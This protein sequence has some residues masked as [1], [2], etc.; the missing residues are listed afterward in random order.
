MLNGCW[1][2]APPMRPWVRIHGK[3]KYLMHLWETRE[4]R[5]GNLKTNFTSPERQKARLEI[6]SHARFL[7]CQVRLNK[8]FAWKGPA[9]KE[10]GNA[11]HLGNLSACQLP[12]RRGTWS[13]TKSR[14]KP[15]A[16][17]VLM[18]LCE[19]LIEEM[20]SFWGYA[21][22]TFNTW[23]VPKFSSCNVLRAQGQ[24]HLAS[25]RHTQSI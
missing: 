18:Q 7:D 16:D 11:E 1:R 23:Y 21:I 24:R 8:A 10:G 5:N 25:Q 6:D 12:R 4:P 13:Q 19:E 3:H 15:P 2:N 20:Q 17:S 14:G 22:L 9:N